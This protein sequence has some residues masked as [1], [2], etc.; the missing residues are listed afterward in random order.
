MIIMKTAFIEVLGESP[1]VKVLDFLLDNRI[2]DYS[3]KQISIESGVSWATI[4]KIFPQMEKKEIIIMTRRVGKAKMYKLNFEN[5][6]V[7][8]LLEFDL[9]VSKSYYKEEEKHKIEA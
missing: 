8:D 9:A 6:T 2:F 5:Q 4:Q 1:V 7:K 3:M